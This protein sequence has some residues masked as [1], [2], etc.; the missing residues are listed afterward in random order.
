M[1]KWTGSNNSRRYMVSTIECF[2]KYA[3]LLLITQKK[4]EKVLEVL[5]LFLKEHMLQATI[6]M[7]LLFAPYPQPCRAS[8]K[9]QIKSLAEYPIN[10]HEYTVK[11]HEFGGV[12]FHLKEWSRPGPTKLSRALSAERGHRGRCLAQLV[13]KD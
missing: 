8:D 1:S 9:E 3:W 6:L 10:V 12:Y 7:V 11:T 5:G 2:S 4:M 13:T